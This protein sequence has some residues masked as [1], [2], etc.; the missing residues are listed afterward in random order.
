MPCIVMTSNNPILF[1]LR[2]KNT[3]ITAHSIFIV[4]R[5]NIDEIKI[6]V[7]KF[8]GRFFTSHAVNDDDAFFNLLMKFVQ[9]G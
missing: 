3:E 2:E 5:I 8:F 7:R 6:F 4:H 1:Q 9:N